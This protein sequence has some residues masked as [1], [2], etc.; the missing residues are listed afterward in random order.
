MRKTL[1]ALAAIVALGSAGIAQQS[2]PMM[3][4]MMPK[5]SDAPSTKD[6]KTSMMKMMRT[7]PHDYTGNA[8]VD[9]MRQMRVHHQG[10]VDMAEV[11]LQHGRDNEV[12]RLARK[13]VD[14]QKN[15]IAEIDAWLRKNGR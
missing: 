2:M 6:Y 10:A 11:V 7:M 14:D 15:E 4:M 5:E 13:I 1:I 12:K 9:F 8:D 3:D